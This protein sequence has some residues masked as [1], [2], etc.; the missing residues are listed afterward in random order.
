MKPKVPKS[1]RERVIKQWLQGTSRDE[2][3]KDNDIGAGT[4]TATCSG[5]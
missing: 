3:A 5:L 2:I 4:V 1:I